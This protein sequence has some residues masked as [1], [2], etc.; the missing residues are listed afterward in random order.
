MYIKRCDQK[1]LGLNS[2]FRYISLCRDVTALNILLLHVQAFLH[3]IP[4]I[5]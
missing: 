4:V 2:Y 1:V 5:Q 3:L